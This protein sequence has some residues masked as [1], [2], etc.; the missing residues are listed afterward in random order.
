[1]VP[2]LSSSI[3]PLSGILQPPASSANKVFNEH[4]DLFIIHHMENWVYFFTQGAEML[5]AIPSSKEK[6]S[7]GK[8]VHSFPHPKSQESKLM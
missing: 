6:L 1:M 4:D 2:H 5:N 7:L 8:P 3:I